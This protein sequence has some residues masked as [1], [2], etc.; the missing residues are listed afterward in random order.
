MTQPQDHGAPPGIPRWVK[1]FGIIAI[2]VIVLVVIA[3]LLGGNHGPGRHL[4]AMATGG[5][6]ALIDAGVRHT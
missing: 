5:Y 6:S 2:V 3:M 1:I 4:G